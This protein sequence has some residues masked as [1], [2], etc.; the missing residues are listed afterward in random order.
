VAPTSCDDNGL[1][2]AREL[3]ADGCKVIVL[4]D[5]HEAAQ[6]GARI[7]PDAHA[8]LAQPVDEQRLTAL[9]A[10]I[11][12]TQASEGTAPATVLRFEGRSLDL[13]SHSLVDENGREVPL[14]H[15]EF[16]LLTLF[17]RSSGRVLSR[18]QLR[19]G[20]SGRDL[21]P[22]DRSIDML[23]ARL[24]RKIEPN[25]K[26][27]CFILTVPGVGYKF[28]PRV[29]QTDL[30]TTPPIEA[31]LK[32][33]S[34][35]PRPAEL[36]QLSVLACQIRGWRALSTPLDPEDESE[37]MS[38]I[39]RAC[40]D[41]AG[42]FRGVVARVL[43]DSILMYFGYIT[44]QEHDPE[45]AVRA[46]LELIAAIRNLGL[47]SALHP[48]IGI[49]TGLMMV[50]ASLGPSDK[51]AATGQAL[52]LALRLQS[53]AP[54]NSV[55]VTSHTREL[56]GDFFNY[57]EMEPLVLA[58][59]L[60]PVP[61]WCVTG[62]STNAGR[63]EALRRPRMLKLVGRTQEMTLLRRCWSKA[64]NGAGQVVVIAGEPGIGKSRLIAEFEEEKSLEL[65]NNLKYFGSP[66]Q[67][68]TP[69][70]A[71]IGELQRAAG[72]THADT[73]SE[74]LAKIATL[75]EGSGRRGI[76]ETTL[77][78]DLLSV[79]TV[80]PNS[81]SELTPQ[82]RKER[83][84]AALL[85]RVE[86]LAA[87][88]PVLVVVEDA[89]WLDP[90]SLEFFTLLVTRL[91]RLPIMVLIAA[92]PEFALPWPIDAHVTYLTLARLDREDAG[93][94]VTHVAGGKPL[95]EEASNQ[96][97]QRTDGVPLFIEELTKMVLE[98]GLLR[99]GDHGYELT[100]PLPPREI[101]L[102]LHAS[103]LARLDRLGSTKEVAQI[104]AVIGRE[105]SYA[106]AS[107]VATLPDK[108]F[109]AALGQLVAAELIFQRGAP[110]DASYQFKHSLVQDA[111]YA[112]LVRTR[113]QQLHGQIARALEEQFPDVAITEPETFAHHFTEAS[114]TESAIDYWQKAGRQAV[115]RSALVEAIKHFSEAIRLV[116]LS[117][118]SPQRTRKELDLHLDLGPA[119]MATK[120]YASA[121]S[122]EVFATA[123]Q[124][125][126]EIGDARERMDVLLGL[127]N[128][129]F[130][131]AELRE[132]LAIAT[133]NFD[134][135]KGEQ[136][137][138]GRA[139]TLMGQTH[140]AMG[141]L[142]EARAALERAI[143]IFACA[144]EEPGTFGVFSSQHVVSLAFV[145][146][147]HFAL[148]NV[149]CGR[150]A[151]HA[152]IERARQLQHPMSL[153]LALVSELLT[154]IPGG[155]DADV[156]QADSVIG[157]CVQN[158]L[159]NFEV[160]ARFARGAILARRGQ[161]RNGIDAMRSAINSA[162]AINSRIFRPVQFASLASA[163][164]KLG[165][166]AEALTLLEE[167]IRVSEST[168]ERR[169]DASLHRLY[170]EVL[171]SANAF[172]AGQRH[173]RLALEVAHAQHA[174]VEESLI[175]KKQKDLKPPAGAS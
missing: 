88:Y 39:H 15:A 103:L 23:V 89:H 109:K 140:A 29:R 159:T 162:E 102:T 94:L 35:A 173:F 13:G 59:D 153:A 26:S 152:S 163:H 80:G 66:H 10:E 128:V 82:R 97:L 83:T 122:L 45:R 93:L 14:T 7:L 106:L 170:G 33:A 167:A 81:V 91:S 169:A 114:L 55:L 37:L 20:I 50:G 147:V 100:G 154:P 118:Q 69:L 130:G 31:Q 165:E 139:Y 32:K 4:T 146:G 48:H 156:N 123:H 63:F 57:R 158:S 143:E 24:R 137:F 115:E 44:A 121:E 46:G 86:N 126:T 19:I 12:A 40:A 49:A 107:A 77:V 101:P 42:R 104:G 21:E 61:V 72:F 90:T 113:R 92:R 51:F 116:R 111:A 30:A 112:S 151:M 38:S 18:D 125:V 99:K 11:A 172:E 84:L 74:R 27:P 3:C 67:T 34:D 135:A 166:V 75:L 155:L 2:V 53:V 54:S 28:A 133:L 68:D 142:L 144:P 8:F 171:L 79:S 25:T 43:G 96:I 52:T 60:A 70:Y 71:V 148:G 141:E 127:F 108:D 136:C 95:P 6:T 85:A 160:W 149:E 16:E 131:R 138:Q 129:H 58:D 64:L 168:G 22:Y 132:A 120:G 41:V 87:I 175:R 36:R 78:A 164:A 105:F 134:L 17:A 1:A 73:P 9:L 56:V 117:P 174:I 145:A 98:S 119:I 65:Y 161:P 5:S 62:E 124:L 47:Q 157:F 110:P 150:T 76:E